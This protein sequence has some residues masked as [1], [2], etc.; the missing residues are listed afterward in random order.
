MDESLEFIFTTMV[1]QGEMLDAVEFIRSI[2]VQFLPSTT[3]MKTLIFQII[4]VS[5]F[6]YKM[7]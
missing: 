6:L 3:I 1:G 2:E 4:M 7:F 5:Y